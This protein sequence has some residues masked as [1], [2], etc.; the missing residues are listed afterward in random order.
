MMDL[1]EIALKYLEKIIIKLLGIKEGYIIL[2][3][4]L[5]SVFTRLY[6]LN[7][8]PYFY[9]DEGFNAETALG[10]MKTGE[11]VR[12]FYQEP[13][14]SLQKPILHYIFLVASFKLFGFGIWQGRIISALFGIGTTYLIYYFSRKYFGLKV[15]VITSLFYISSSC[16]IYLDR[17]MK[18]DSQ[19][20]FFAFLSL[21][22]FYR[23]YSERNMKFSFI[24]GIF[25]GLAMISKPTIIYLILG[26]FIFLLIESARYKKIKENIILFFMFICGSIVFYSPWIIYY[27][28]HSSD[29]IVSTIGKTFIVG[30]LRSYGV[31]L[32]DLFIHTF[33]SETIRFVG[34]IGLIYIALQKKTVYRYFVSIILSGFIFYLFANVFLRDYLHLVHLLILICAAIFLVELLNHEILTKRNFCIYIFVILICFSGLFV[35]NPSKVFYTPLMTDDVEIEA[36]KYLEKS[37]DEN[38]IIFC[39]ANIG[40]LS[41]KKY[42]PIDPT[43]KELTC[44][45]IYEKF[46]PK[47][48]VIDRKVRVWGLPRHFS[49]CLDIE[50]IKTFGEREKEIEIYII[51]GLK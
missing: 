9:I 7:N 46:K 47:Y 40:V 38:E 45:E 1:S 31:T 16:A 2:F 37:V 18:I 19:A 12:Y 33:Y 26:N 27:F 3:I 30:S 41:G 28:N 29:S 4:L 34:L 11:M 24:S 22:L 49:D 14:L 48:L 35:S 21:I 42:V 39:N 10:L 50:L 36:A 8:A 15:A 23:A 20:T 17:S 32:A 25:Y 51:K 44:Q 5:I 6:N 13:V 43:I